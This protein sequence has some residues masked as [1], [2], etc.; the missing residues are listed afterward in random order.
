MKTFIPIPSK[1]G[2]VYY[3]KPFDIINII[4]YDNG[5]V[6]VTYEVKDRVC[7]V[8]TLLTAQEL[9]EA[10]DKSEPDFSIF[11]GNEDGE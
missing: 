7:C 8:T 1:D 4:Q 2:S 9:V 11:F 10:I 6:D 5:S 3:I